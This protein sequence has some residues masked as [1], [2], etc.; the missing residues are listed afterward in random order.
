MPFAIEAEGF[1][2]NLGIASIGSFEDRGDV[3]SYG[4]F[5]NAYYTPSITDTFKLR[6]GGGAGYA[7]TEVKDNGDASSF[8]VFKAKKADF[9]YQ[10][11]AGAEYALTENLALGLTYTYRM[12]SKIDVVDDDGVPYKFKVNDTSLVNLGLRYSF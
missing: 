7:Q 9:V 3:N 5:V 10:A 2:Q 8:T 12:F 11:R 6:I 4:G 1:Y